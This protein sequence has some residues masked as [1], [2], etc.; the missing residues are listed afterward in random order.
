[1]SAK[2]AHW[3]SD[4][5]CSDDYEDMVVGLGRDDVPSAEYLKMFTEGMCEATSRDDEGTTKDQCDATSRVDEGTSDATGCDEDMIKDH[6]P[7][8]GRHGPAMAAVLTHK[9]TSMATSA[10]PP[11][12]TTM[13][14]IT[15]DPTA[16][17]LCEA[18]DTDEGAQQGSAG[19]SCGRPRSRPPDGRTRW[20]LS[21]ACS[22]RRGQRAAGS[23]RAAPCTSWASRRQRSLGVIE[24]CC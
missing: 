13:A 8:P 3:A 23:D 2:I 16:K 21:L 1:V 15:M 14:A 20:N 4:D 24:R 17:D 7:A 19:P 6:D 10:M 11:V 12:G 9:M 18:T 5:I 22:A